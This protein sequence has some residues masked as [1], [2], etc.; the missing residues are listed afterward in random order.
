MKTVVPVKCS[1]Q[2]WNIQSSLS[3]RLV[4]R[5]FAL[6]L[7]V[8]V[9]IPRGW[10]E[11]SAKATGSTA[12]GRPRRLGPRPRLTEYSEGQNLEKVSNQFHWL[13]AKLSNMCF[14]GTASVCRT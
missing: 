8:A 5:D 9:C 10:R 11:G 2:N 13:W 3:Q 4:E 6:H 7:T 12:R 14:A 1:D